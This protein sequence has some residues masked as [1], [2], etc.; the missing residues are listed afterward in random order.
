[1]ASLSGKTTSFPNNTP[2]CFWKAGSPFS[3]F[4][5][6]QGFTFEYKLSKEGEEIRKTI[7]YSETVFMILKTLE[8]DPK[9]ETLI[10]KILVF[11]S[12]HKPNEVK[13][14]GRQVKNFNEKHW[15]EIKVKRMEE[16]LRLKF[17]QISSL[18]QK[19]LNTGDSPMYECSPYDKIW[20][21]GM[22]EDEFLSGAK[23]R[24]QNLLGLS[25]VKVRDE[26]RSQP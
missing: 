2:V 8:F 19:L 10:K 13:N 3:N 14:C 26:L 15:D 4:H 18:K 21:V 12:E 7:F 11:D 20:G 25:L 16:A 24:G 9:N 23:P 5:R 17:S 6:T 1:M 22:T